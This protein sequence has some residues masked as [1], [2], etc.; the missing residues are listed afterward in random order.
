MLKMQNL[1]NPALNKPFRKILKLSLKN[2]LENILLLLHCMTY[3][4]AL[5]V[6]A[7]R[8][9]PEGRDFDCPCGH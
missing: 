7:L 2:I 3:A 5:F 9:K 6:E 8:Y 1:R 4:V